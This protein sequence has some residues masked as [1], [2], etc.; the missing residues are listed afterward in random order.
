MDFALVNPLAFFIAFTAILSLIWR[1][2]R[3]RVS[4]LSDG[5]GH[6]QE[7][8]KAQIL[9]N[10]KEIADSHETAAVLAELIR[11]D[12]AG[13]WPPRANHSHSTWPAA[14]R[15][16]REIYLELAP[17]LPKES[18]SLDDE[19]NETLIT[20][21][22][23]RF[24]KLLHDRVDLDQVQQLL[25]AADAG[26]WDVFSRDV[27]NA[28]YCCIA[29]S[30]HAYRWGTIPVVRAAQLEKVVDL[31]IE[32]EDTWTYLQRHFGCQSQSG[33]NTSNLVLNF[34]TNGQHIYK[35]NTGMSDLVTS[36]EEAFG[37][38]F[39]DVE[40]LGLPIY[41]D[42]VLATTSFARGDKT[43]CA[44][45]MENIASQLRPLLSAYYDKMHNQKIALKVWLPHVQG[46][47]AWGAGYIDDATGEWVKFDG[48]SG[49]QVLLFQCLDAFLGLEPYLSQRDQ[50]RNVPIRQR[51]L[52][53]AFE[54]HSFREKLSKVPE[55]EAEAQ[56]VRNFD[57]ILKRIRAFRSAH[58]TRAKTY[59]SQPAPE[60]LPMT[61]GKSL[62][63]S[64]IETS[65]QFLDE[66]M[67]GRLAQ[68]V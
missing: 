5:Y 18:P 16:Y 37:R 31:P 33:N 57:E 39:Y 62:L 59:L 12:G 51:A 7:A 20:S 1:S 49:N 67:V 64:D 22:R 63:K 2:M 4:V 15:P 42:M 6:G 48:L 24:R 23:T 26:R 53:E 44:V 10:I 55:D 52:R 41:H 35:I 25:R 34:D 17:L 38:I 60:R 58:R 43:M 47:F 54:R 66:F 46:F 61:A 65:L 50:E 40:T 3:S 32:L 68:T 11:T 19:V 28:F 8:T 27:Y 9:E 14:L 56:I 30:R 13:S 45:Y 21:F 36:G 29:S